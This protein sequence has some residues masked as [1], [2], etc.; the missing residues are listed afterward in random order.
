MAPKLQLQD[1]VAVSL[2]ASATFLPAGGG[3]PKIFEDREL[4]VKINEIAVVRP[5]PGRLPLGLPLHIMRAFIFMKDQ[6]GLIAVRPI[7]S[8]A[9]QFWYRP[10]AATQALNLLTQLELNTLIE[11]TAGGTRPGDLPSY[12][13]GTETQASAINMASRLHLTFKPG[14]SLV[15]I[16]NASLYLQKVN[17]VVRV[18]RPA[19]IYPPILRPADPPPPP[20]AQSEP[21]N[22]QQN[23]IA[24]AWTANWWRELIAADDPSSVGPELTASNIAILDTGVHLDHPAFIGGGVVAPPDALGYA[25]VPSGSYDDSLP[26]SVQQVCHGTHVCSIISG[27]GFQPTNTSPTYAKGALPGVTV[28]S[29]N[30]FSYSKQAGYYLSPTKLKSA[31]HKI[32]HPPN[33]VAGQVQIR[34]INLSI[35]MLNID[36]DLRDVFHSLEAKGIVVCAC[37]G[38]RFLNSWPTTLTQ[39]PESEDLADNSFQVF[40]PARLKTVMAVG[41]VD[42]FSK[43]S[44]F[45]RFASPAINGIAVGTEPNTFEDKGSGTTIVNISAPGRWIWAAAPQ[46]RMYYLSTVDGAAVLDGTSMAAPLVT[47]AAAYL[48]DVFPHATAHQIRE[49]LANQCVDSSDVP[50]SPDNQHVLTDPVPQTDWR[51]IYGAGV[52]DWLRLGLVDIPE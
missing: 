7:V 43:H 49:A 21:N 8:T 9:F 22:D 6:F 13:P 27:R 33:E 37:T 19:C 2:P 35:W 39:Y 12:R 50:G 48:A 30:I 16:R 31:L 23:R 10:D 24:S 15:T 40:F 47:A 41:A 52:L 51:Y 46:G 32:L 14:T 20:A 1:G 4:L 11:L 26:T 45:S 36:Q 38:N 25:A 34:V 29:F 44:P 3:P 5:A 42:R 28:M 18:E 17:H